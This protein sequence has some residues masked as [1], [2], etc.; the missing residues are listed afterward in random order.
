MK[1]DA[2]SIHGAN[3]LALLLRDLPGCLKRYRKPTI[4]NGSANW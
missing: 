2:N 3:A 1:T 4:R